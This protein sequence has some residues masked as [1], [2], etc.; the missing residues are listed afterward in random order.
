MTK[1]FIVTVSIGMN[2]KMGPSDVEKMF[3]SMISERTDVHSW[4]AEVRIDEEFEKI[5]GQD[6]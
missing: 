6:E 1:N 5:V 3:D 4:G 2:Q